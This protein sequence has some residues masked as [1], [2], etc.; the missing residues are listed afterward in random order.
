MFA[1]ITGGPHKDGALALAAILGTVSQCSASQRTGSC[2]ETKV[3]QL[4]G[5]TLVRCLV[6]QQWQRK[7]FFEAN[8]YD[9]ISLFGNIWSLILKITTFYV[10]TFWAT[11][12][13]FGLLFLQTSVDTETNRQ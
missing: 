10:A 13:Q 2:G 11:F 5:H 8:Q 6:W 4:L 3:L 12:G 1:A 9:H 7:I